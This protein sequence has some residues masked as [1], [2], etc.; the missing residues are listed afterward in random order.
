MEI[1]TAILKALPV[2]G[3]L[4]KS[5]IEMG[6]SPDDAADIVAR[7]LKSRQAEYEAAKAADK[8]ALKDKHGVE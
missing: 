8:Q 3:E 5:L 2:L 4:I 1:F 6:H 7:D